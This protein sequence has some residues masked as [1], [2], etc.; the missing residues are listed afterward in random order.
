MQGVGEVM[1]VTKNVEAY[2]KLPDSFTVSD[3]SDILSISKK[4]AANYCSRW[5][6]KGF[7]KRE[8]RAKYVKL[9]KLMGK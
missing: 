1:R 7:L 3:L 8:G 4:I 6:Q 9:I 2:N 5:L